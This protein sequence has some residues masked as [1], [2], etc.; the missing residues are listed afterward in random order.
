MD[1]PLTIIGLS[2][3]GNK[4]NDIKYFKDHLP[5]DS[6]IIIEPFAGSF[7]VIRNIYYDIKYKRVINDKDESWFGILR[8][9]RKDPEAVIK[10][11]YD[12]WEKLT[13]GGLTR[14]YC[15][16]S[17][18]LCVRGMIKE[19]NSAL[20]NIFLLSSLL[21]SSTVTNDD[22]LKVCE[23]YKNNKDAF[24]FLDPPY[25]DSYNKSYFTDQ[26]TSKDLQDNT[27]MFVDFKEI[28]NSYKCKV[29]LIINNNYLTRYIYSD[30]IK[31]EYD[32]VYQL[33]KRK[34]SHLIITNY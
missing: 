15:K 8:D 20:Q 6:K 14:K 1:K 11:I 5:L 28:L 18:T 31:G 26:A 34:N 21:N 25:L 29:M 3:L 12:E 17:D 10:E 32:K 9:I 16:F 23:K 30:Y 22:F 13:N 24:I 4:Q 27:K 19:P 33:T 2:R 7:A